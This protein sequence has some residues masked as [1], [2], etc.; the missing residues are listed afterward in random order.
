MFVFIDKIV[1]IFLERVDDKIQLVTLINQLTDGA[2]LLTESEL[3]LVKSV[4]ELVSLINFSLLLMFDIYKSPI[5]FCTL[6]SQDINFIL[7]DFNSLLHL[8]K[9]LTGCL[10]LT[11]VPVTGVF[12]LFVK[13]DERVQFELRVLLLLGQY[14]H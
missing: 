10:D 4:S 3:V 11:N 12:D 9:I 8:S 2:E 5:F 14:I 6:S 7:Q 13:S 1:H